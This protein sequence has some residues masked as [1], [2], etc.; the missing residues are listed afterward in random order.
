MLRFL[1]SATYFRIKS[2]SNWCVQKVK[3][4][5]SHWVSKASFKQKKVKKISPP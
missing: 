1:T 2:E 5:N 4:E 3:I